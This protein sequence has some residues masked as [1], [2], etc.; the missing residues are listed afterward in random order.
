M[1]KDIISFIVV[2]FMAIWVT[3]EVSANT[4]TVSGVLDTN[5]IP[6]SCRY[7][8]I[9]EV[10]VSVTGQYSMTL[11][12]PGLLLTGKFIVI[13]IKDS[14]NTNFNPILGV[15]SNGSSLSGQLTANVTYYLHVRGSANCPE[16]TYPISYSANIT[17]PGDITLAVDEAVEESNEEVIVDPQPAFF[18]GRINN[19]DTASPIVIYPISTADGTALHIYSDTGELLLVVPATT[20]ANAPNN[21]SENIIIAEGND[22]IVA[23]ISGEGSGLWQINAPQYNGKTYVIIFSELF[24]DGGYTS[25]EN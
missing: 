11:L 14:P 22:V 3:G 4:I 21:P 24:V 18:D 1:R 6:L 23:R 7:T 10:S 5:D 2:M 17:G 9:T 12:Q 20:L 16:T 8:E 25:Y 15:D 13:F 19:W